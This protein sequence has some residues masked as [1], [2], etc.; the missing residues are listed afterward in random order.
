MWGQQ[1]PQRRGASRSSTSCGGS[2]SATPAR[3]SPRS[4]C[5]LEQNWRTSI[6][7][8]TEGMTLFAV[9]Q[10]GLFPLLHLGRPWFAYWLFPY[11]SV[12]GTWPQVRSALPWDAAAVSTYFLVSLMFWYL[13]MIPDLAALRDQRARRCT[14]RIGSTASARSAGAGRTQQWRHHKVGVLAAR[15]PRDAARDLG[16]LDRQPRLL[17]RP[18]CRAG[19]R[20]SSRRSSSRAR[21]SPGF[22][23]VMTLMHARAA[24]G[25]SSTT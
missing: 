16:A 8:F 15:R 10:A 12:M 18:G 22:A 6:N 19:T 9:M 25:S 14:R 11:P 3:S 20:R 5:V 23:M 21:S 7:R 4:C 24:R 13:G 2:A 1:H 17:D